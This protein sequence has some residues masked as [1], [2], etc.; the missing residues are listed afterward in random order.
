MFYRNTTT[1]DGELPLPTFQRG[2]T[3]TTLD[4]IFTSPDLFPHRTSSSV[5]Y[6]NAE[7]SD[8]FLVSVSF[9]FD[10]ASALGKGIWR[11]NP[12]LALN[13]AF[14]SELSTLLQ[15]LVPSLSPPASPQQR[16]DSLKNKV[17]LFIQ[18]FSRRRTQN[19]ATLEC[20]L[21][22]KRDRL[23]QKFQSAPTQNFQLPIIEH[24][25]Q[26]VQKE[27]VELL[28]LH[29]GKHWR[30]NGETSAGYLK[31]TI[32]TRQSHK[33]IACLRHPTT[34]VPSFDPPGMTEAAAVFY[35]QLYSPDPVDHSAIQ[36]LLDNMPADLALSDATRDALLRP[37]SLSDILA[38]AARSPRASSPGPD[39]LPYEILL[40]ILS[41]DA[42]TTLVHQVFLDALIHGLFP[43]SWQSTCVSLLP[44]K[45]DL[46]SLKN[47]RPIALINTDAKVFTRLLNSRIVSVADKLIS[48]YQTGFVRGRFIADNGKLT[49]I[50]MEQAQCSQ[51]SAIG[52][53]LDQEKA[54]DRVH[55]SYLRRVLQRFN[56]PLP[57]IN[58]IC[59]L[60]FS[61]KLRINVN[62]HLSR[63]VTQ[64]RGLHQGDPLS[65][66]LFNLAFEPLLRRILHDP[67]FQGFSLPAAT[68]DPIPPSV[69]FLAYADDLLVFLNDPSHMPRLQ[70]H[71]QTYASASNAR[72]NMHKTHAFS[73]SGAPSPL[74]SPVLQQHQITEWHDRHSPLPVTYLGFPLSTSTRQRDTYLSTLLDKIQAACNIHLS[75]SLS[76]RGR[77]TVLNTLI[78]FKLWHVLRVIS[79]PLSF[80]AKVRS[81][82]GKFLQH[83]MFPPI[84]LDNLCVPL[85]QG[86]LGVL[87][88]ALQ[89]QALQLRWLNPLC[90]SSNSAGLVH[91]WLVALL[92]SA[93]PG[94]DP[95]LTLLCPDLRPAI[96]RHLG[97]AFHNLFAAID[98]LPHSFQH[99]V[100]NLPTCLVLPLTSV[101]LPSDEAPIFPRSWR[102]LRI[103]D[104]FILDATFGT[105]RRRTRHERPNHPNIIHSFFRQIDRHICSLQP[106]LIRACLPESILQ[107]HYPDLPSRSGDAVDPSPLLAAMVPKGLWS[108]LSTRSFRSL[109]SPTLFPSP[110]FD[111]PLSS[112]QWRKFWSFRLHHT[113]R[114]LWFRFL[115]DKLSCRATL[116]NIVPSIFPSPTC[117]ICSAQTD[118]PEHFLLLCPPKLAAWTT[119]WSTHFGSIPTE[120]SLTAALRSFTFP[121][122][123]DS[124]LAPA[125]IL[126]CLLLATWRHHWR[127]IF[128]DVPL[129]SDSL[130]TA[131]TCL[132]DTFL[133]ELAL[134][135]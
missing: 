96:F 46:S 79:V 75:R 116:H 94:T 52:L 3:S 124:T 58:T 13:P 21:Q 69:K 113:V 66:V 19:L 12:R 49:Q 43:P 93:S 104:A 60:F 54:Y 8:H 16:W 120:S 31:R 22:S 30:E 100:L 37:F 65:P 77:A 51:S 73:L 126:S 36:E 70:D 56:F 34:D 134:D 57:L 95:R 63:E 26:I 6:I 18:S 107:Q 45:G 114:S 87:D 62:G 121:P 80:F 111:P 133:A 129:T 14:R 9:R 81:I 5:T 48:P 2:P 4:Y 23:L 102:Q 118:S 42:C 103:S 72:I 86:G 7:W 130:M 64:K 115:H 131:A 76:V 78:L 99:T 83:N 92:R 15:T 11:A 74:W 91:P 97:S 28:A 101:I 47:W 122:V 44:K 40:L 24:Q 1:V 117:A 68:G 29:A 67:N 105:L 123:H 55:P 35:E 98:V 128:D 84:K 88:P 20:K 90:E 17:R 38:G 106:Y 50:I 109:V 59:N 33:T 41:N 25:L 119:F 125:S 112:I 85:S 10:S 27:R 135:A 71:L 32:A 132:Y 53:L 89:Q 127:F 82:M 61:T 110:V 39:G 108:N